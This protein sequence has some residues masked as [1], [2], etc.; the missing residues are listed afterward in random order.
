MELYL[1]K[2]TI[3]LA[4]LFTFYKI[5]LENSSIHRFKRFYL[6]GSIAA[7]LLIPQIT[8]TTYVEPSPI[9][10]TY[11]AETAQIL[12]IETEVSN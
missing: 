1:L 12:F 10:P 7:A 4:L 5:V 11:T 8:F 2:S 9:V 6:L 3:C